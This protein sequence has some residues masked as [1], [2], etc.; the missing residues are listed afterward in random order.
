MSEPRADAYSETLRRHLGPQVLAAFADE[1]VS[2]LYLNP[3]DRL[4]RLDT[5]S[6]GRVSSGHRLGAAETLS[7]LNTVASLVGE[8]LTAKR[9]HLQAELPRTVFRGARLQAFV[10]P[11]AA[12]PC[13]VLRKPAAA[14]YTL[15][16]W[17]RAGILSAGQADLLRRHVVGRSN[18]LV[19]G[20]TR[21]GKTTLANALLHAMG[22]LCP[23]DRVVILEDTRELQCP[24]PDTLALRADAGLD[25]TDLVRMILRASPDRIVVG[26]VRDAS[27]LDLLDA[28]STGHPGGIATVH[29][30]DALGALE[31]LDRLAQRNK[32]PSQRELIA[33]AIQLVLVLAGGSQRRFVRELVAVEGL[34]RDGH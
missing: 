4:L 23:A 14:V 6:R 13:F 17:S 11:I 5:R 9:P 20:G 31:R 33:E 10:P 19:A 32:V 12:G 22:E 30:T 3:E 1:D 18:I 27:A 2:E 24:A 8:T 15:E 29:A 26:E 25:L 28:W 16:D 34:D 7:F 21:S